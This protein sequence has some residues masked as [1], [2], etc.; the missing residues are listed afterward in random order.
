M[1]QA[2]HNKVK[3]L[4]H[5]LLGSTNDRAGV[6]SVPTLLHGVQAFNVSTGVIFYVHV[7]DSTAMVSTTGD[8]AA[9]T[10]AVPAA[11]SPTT[12]SVGA[13]F[14]Y[15]PSNP[16][17]LDNGFAYAIGSN[18]NSTAAFSTVAAN[19]GV[20]NFDYEAQRST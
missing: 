9:K 4:K 2:F 16:I 15:A 17:T 12:V 18:L 6:T 14:I 19:L 5:V 11:V 3:S 10:F 20:V 13:G 7:F 8:A 1:G